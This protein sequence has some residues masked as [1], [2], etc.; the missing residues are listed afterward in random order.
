MNKKNMPKMITGIAISLIC[1]ISL[2]LSIYFGSI[3]NTSL[4]K[5]HWV[6][7]YIF[8]AFSFVSAGLLIGALL[9]D[10]HYKYEFYV[11]LLAFVVSFILVFIVFYATEIFS[12][13]SGINPYNV[14]EMTQKLVPMLYLINGISVI[15]IIKTTA[16]RIKKLIKK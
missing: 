9:Y 15:G 1:I 4:K 7:S 8:V 10:K 3:V 2:A 6:L 14:N 12:Y 13:S 5:A 11:S 16:P